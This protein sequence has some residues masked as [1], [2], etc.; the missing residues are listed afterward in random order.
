MIPTGAKLIN[1]REN[2]KVPASFN[3]HHDGLRAEDFVQTS[4]NIGIV[5][6]EMFLLVDIDHWNED[7]E[8]FIDRFSETPTWTQLSPRGRHYLFRTPSGWRGTNIKLKAPDGV[9]FGDLKTLGYVVG[10]GSV[11]NGAEYKMIHDVDPVIAPSF[12]LG[13]A[14]RGAA[15]ATAGSVALRAGIPNG[16]HDAFLT[17]YAGWLRGRQ[18]LGPEGIQKALGAAVTLLDD[19]DP[20][21]PY[22]ERDFVRIA[23]SSSKWEA[24]KE[25]Y[26]ELLHPRLR[27]AIEIELVGPVIDWVVRGF[28]PTGELVLLYGKGGIGKSSFGSWLAYEVSRQNKTFAFMGTEETSARFYGRAVLAG[29]NRAKCFEILHAGQMVFPRDANDLRA[30]VAESQIDFLYMDSIYTHFMHQEGQ[31]EAVRARSALAPLAEIAHDT[32]CTILGVFHTNKAGNYLGSVEMENVARCVLEAKRKLKADT[33][34]ISVTKTNLYNPG[35]MMRFKGEEMIFMDEQG[36]V[37]QEM[38]E[39][40]KIIPMTIIVPKRL[41][42]VPDEDENELDDDEIDHTKP[43]PQTCREFIEEWMKDHPDNGIPNPNIISAITDEWSVRAIQGALR[44]IK[45]GTIKINGNIQS[46]E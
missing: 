37:Q 33:L 6:D 17:A 22:T 1:L 16:E 43:R 28:V 42:D 39:E 18:G 12:L 11:V 13:M 40:G 7:S 29:A 25:E 24:G 34:S 30:M 2:S 21:N 27:P 10:P 15:P 46:D 19:V 41:E 9:I 44:E 26:V 8:E 5:L 32:G 45:M 38:D 14:E 4:R 3:G 20:A 23:R 35:T 36:N 31:N